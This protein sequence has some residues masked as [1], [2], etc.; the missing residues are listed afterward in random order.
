MLLLCVVVIS[1]RRNR[2]SE[3][4]EVEIREG[5]ESRERFEECWFV[6]AFGERGRLSCVYWSYGYELGVRLLWFGSAVAV[7]QEEIN[8][9]GEER[10]EGLN[11]DGEREICGERLMQR[12]R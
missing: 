8:G 4:R 1:R 2:K 10:D 6:L 3:A 12:G 7:C 9:I 5:V 11:G